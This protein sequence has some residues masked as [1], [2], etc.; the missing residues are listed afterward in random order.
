MVLKGKNYYLA[1][2]YPVYLA[3]GCVVIDDAIDRFRQ[4]W[5]KPVIVALS[6]A[7]GAMFAPLAM[8]IL[9]IDQFIP[10]MNWLPI[11]VPRSEHQHAR[12]ALR[13]RWPRLYG[14]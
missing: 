13:E 3:A 7:G 11:K 5:L 8:P 14:S 1:P 2:I 9:P 12:A 4:F 6:L 10:Y